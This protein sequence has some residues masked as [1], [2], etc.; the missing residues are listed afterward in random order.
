MMRP[1]DLA[2]AITAGATEFHAASMTTEDI[3]GA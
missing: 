3:I 1:T 2:L